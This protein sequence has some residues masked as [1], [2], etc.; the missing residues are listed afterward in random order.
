MEF[1]VLLEV[2]WDL[3]ICAL[4]VW[5]NTIVDY[6]GGILLE[7]IPKTHSNCV[8]PRRDVQHPPQETPCTLKQG[9]M[10]PA[11]RYS[12]QR[13]EAVGSRQNRSIHWWFRSGCRRVPSASIKVSEQ[14]PHKKFFSRVLSGVS[15]GFARILV[16]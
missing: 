4:T 3:I 16:N 6:R 14:D 12:A 10:V 2:S 8:R 13:L 9:Y 1:R 11:T 15:K 7:C 5:L